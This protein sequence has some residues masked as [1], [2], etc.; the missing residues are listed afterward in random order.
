MKRLFSILFA[1]VLVLSLSLVTAVVSADPGPRI[2]FWQSSE[3]ASGTA[4]FSTT[5]SHSASYSAHLEAYV[6]YAP[7]DY[8]EA[9]VANP[10]GVT[11]LNDLA[12]VSLWYYCPAG[13][14]D[15][16]PLI[17]VWLDTNGVYST[18]FPPTGD[19]EWLLGM[20]DDVTTPGAWVEVTLSEITWVRAT[21]G[22][23]YGAG[24]AGLTAAKAETNSGIYDTLGVCP[25]LAIGIETGGPGTYISSRA[26][27][28][29]F[30]IDDLKINDV[31]YDLGPTSSV[32]L[33][34]EV[35]SI[36]A[37]SVTPTSI[38]FGTLYPGQSSSITTVTVE[39]IGTVTVG[40]DASVSPTG[41]VFDY[42]KLDDTSPPTTS[43]GDWGI[44]D[45]AVSDSDLAYTQLVVP[46][47][48]SAQGTETATLIFEATA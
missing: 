10:T 25:L 44:T 18:D 8:H 47:N 1:L 2:G 21:G 29:D 16:A 41:K 43:V 42:L 27:D 6:A 30:Y 24:S 39:N 12:S 45:L 3:P 32:G 5:Y 13:D 20:I 40:V 14:N 35:P 11:L 7:N 38:D 15:V 28:Q 22:T 37:I 34:A 48:Y 33:T 31:T 46:S 9:Y 36:I 17:D 26:Y 23:V 19:D 4:E